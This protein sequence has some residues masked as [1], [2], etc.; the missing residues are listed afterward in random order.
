MTSPRPNARNAPDTSANIAASM[1]DQME[2]YTTICINISGA[3]ATTRIAVLIILDAVF[4][5]CMIYSHRSLLSL[6]DNTRR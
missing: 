3:H 2:I 6:N 1:T 5:I 4:L